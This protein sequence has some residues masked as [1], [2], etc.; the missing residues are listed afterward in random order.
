MHEGQYEGQH[1]SRDIKDEYDLDKESG[2]PIQET[3]AGIVNKMARGK[4][5][6]KLLKKSSTNSIGLKTT[7]YQPQ[8]IFHMGEDA[9]S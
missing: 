1:I 5:T 6:Y 9:A 3:L 2:L 7:L 4:L 8:L